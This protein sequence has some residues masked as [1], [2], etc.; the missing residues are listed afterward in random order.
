M[1]QADIP[2]SNRCVKN[3]IP[4]LAMMELRHASDLL[5]AIGTD[6]AEVDRRRGLEFHFKQLLP[7]VRKLPV[8]GPRRTLKALAD[9]IVQ[10]SA[11]IAFLIPSRIGECPSD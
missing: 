4:H 3:G 10:E 6:K 2:A 5:R 9:R 1:V 8:V 7:D 11:P